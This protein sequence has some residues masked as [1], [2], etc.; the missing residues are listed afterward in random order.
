MGLLDTITIEVVSFRACAP[1]P[2]LLPFF[3]CIL[4][5]VF[6]EGLQH[7]MRFCLDHHS[8]IKMAAFQSYLQSG[9]QKKVGWVR[10]GSDDVFGHKFPGEKESVKR[11]V[12]MVQQPV[13][14]S[15]KFG[16][17]SSHIFMQSQ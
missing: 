6:C 16:T 7:R 11:C 14:L 9:K 15:P 4:Q 8:C 2:V 13:S 3:K 17:K 5:V 10:G 1:F 12:V